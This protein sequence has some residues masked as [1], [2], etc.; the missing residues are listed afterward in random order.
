MRKMFAV[1]VRNPSDE[2]MKEL[3]TFLDLDDTTERDILKQL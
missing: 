3:V 1:I 2:T